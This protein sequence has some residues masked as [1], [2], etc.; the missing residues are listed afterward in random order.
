MEYRETHMSQSDLFSWNMERDP[1]LRSTIVSV[2]LLDAE[3]DWDRLVRTIDRG[4]RLVPRLRERLVRV[5]FG[6]APPKWAPDPDFDL[7][8]HVR[9]A[10]LPQPATLSAVVDFAR[11][12]AMTAFDPV[13]PLWRS[14]VLTGLDG[15]GCA[16][17]LTV[18]HSL[19]D[20]IGG[21]RIATEMLD[22]DRAGT[23]RADAG[24]A[25]RQHH[26]AARYRRVELGGRHRS[27]PGRHHRD[28]AHRMASCHPPGA[29][30]P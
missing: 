12:E 5:P 18:H 1:A 14:T 16:V 2:L 23:D 17:V 22:V 8:W 21:I 15:G 20:G 10:A 26:R 24:A 4:T 30:G 25:R 27:P 11:T 3:P 19:T 13:R 9:R 28:T 6:L 7:L 29:G